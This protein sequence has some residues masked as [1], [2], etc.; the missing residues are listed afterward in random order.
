VDSLFGT[1]AYQSTMI[2]L[3]YT[4]SSMLRP[5]LNSWHTIV[6]QFQSDDPSSTLSRFSK[7]SKTTIDALFRFFVLLVVFLGL[8]FAFFHLKLTR[9]ITYG[10]AELIVALA[11]LTKAIDDMAGGNFSVGSTVALLGG[12][13]IMVRGLQNIDE[14]LR[15]EA[16][17]EQKNGIQNGIGG[18]RYE[19]WQA[20]F[21]GPYKTSSFIDR[22]ERMEKAY[23]RIRDARRAAAAQNAVS[24]E[25]RP[26]VA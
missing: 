25:E 11:A 1:N 8:G 24:G 18:A 3:S 21:Y 19:F 16:E 4:S 13:Y 15:S 10:I 26:T 23:T 7:A 14:S 5:F 12:I 6:G 17:T 20:A 22:I 2:F 9:K